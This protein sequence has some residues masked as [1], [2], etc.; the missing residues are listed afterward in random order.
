MP[1]SLSK[2]VCSKG[3]NLIIGTQLLRNAFAAH[4]PDTPIIAIGHHPLGALMEDE[5]NA[6]VREMQAAGINIYL[7][8]HTHRSNI[9]TFGDRK[10]PLIQMCCGTNMER[11]KDQDPTDMMFYVGTYDLDKKRGSVD[12]VCALQ[13]RSLTAVCQ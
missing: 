2:R 6:V 11:R 10:F 7:C 9:D 1:V 13:K 5:R 4:R 3:G 8:G 12:L